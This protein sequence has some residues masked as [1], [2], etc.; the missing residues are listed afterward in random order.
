MN[1][2]NIFILLSIVIGLVSYN[3]YLSVRLHRL[4]RSSR[5]SIRTRSLT[6]G[7]HWTD[8]ARWHEDDRATGFAAEPVALGTLAFMRR[9]AGAD[10][11]ATCTGTGRLHNGLAL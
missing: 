2:D 3:V 5:T 10:L 4:D 8:G 1:Y 7:S 9:K 6:K 11:A